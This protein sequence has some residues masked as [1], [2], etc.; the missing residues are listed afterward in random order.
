MRSQQDAHL[1]A[2]WHHHRLIHLQQVVR[3]LRRLVRD[4]IG[5]GRGCADEL[6]AILQIVVFPLPLIASDLDG[7]I[8]IG[9]VFLIQHRAGRRP[10]HAD[11]NQQGDHGPDHFDAGVLMERVGL[12]A[13]AFP[14]LEQRIEHHTEHHHENAQAD[15]Q[16]QRVDVIDAHRDVG[17]R[18][19]QIQRPVGHHRLNP[20]RPA[21]HPKHLSPQSH[22]LFSTDAAM[23]E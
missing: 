19:R 9:G 2:D 12:M 16:N 6:H 14:V 22:V 17:L 23:A 4:L 20:A 5:G 8:G 10:G 7:E 1:L 15:Q 18:R 3:A 13:D 21:R 11:Q